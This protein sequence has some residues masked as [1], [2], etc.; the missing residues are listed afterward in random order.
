MFVGKQKKLTKTVAVFKVLR[1]VY[2]GYPEVWSK[3]EEIKVD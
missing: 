1:E 2:L 3:M